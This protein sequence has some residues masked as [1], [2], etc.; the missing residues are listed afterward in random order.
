MN[1]SKPKQ[2]RFRRKCAYCGEW[3]INPRSMVGLPAGK[4]RSESHFAHRHCV[5]HGQS[6]VYVASR[7][8]V[9]ERS[10]MWRKFRDAGIPITSTWIDEAGP[11]ET[12]NFEELWLRIFGEIRASRYLV[13][14]AEPDDFPLKGALI[15]AGI[16]IG[17][18]KPV[19]V[20]LPGVKLEARS[21]RPIGSWIN[22]HG[23]HRNDDVLSALR[24]VMK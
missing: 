1:K 16:A 19:I 7:A 24:G 14:Y 2:R 8:T 15:E 6:C 13:L 9:P 21:Q 3:E 5:A 20:C 11:G 4:Y 18:G 10:A 17:L 22:Y 12:E 23:V